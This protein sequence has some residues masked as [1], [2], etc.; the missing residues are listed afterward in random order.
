[1]GGEETISTMTREG[2]KE[3]L[4]DA[5]ALL[6]AVTLDE[7]QLLTLEVAIRKGGE[8]I[9]EKGTKAWLKKTR[10]SCSKGRSRFRTTK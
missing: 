5:F 3:D 1:M 9:P 10:A 2:L 6:E 7:K 4:P 8:S